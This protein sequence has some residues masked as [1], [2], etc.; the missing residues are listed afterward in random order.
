MQFV[1]YADNG[2]TAISLHDISDDSLVAVST[3]NLPEFFLE[4]R[5]VF[6]KDWSEN[7]GILS[8]LE[9]AG[10]IKV[11]GVTV[12]IGHVYAYKCRLLV[13]IG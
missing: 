8:A 7:E 13:D 3:V 9:E 2:R 12:P 6:I 11:T 1:T 10:L 4:D 5:H